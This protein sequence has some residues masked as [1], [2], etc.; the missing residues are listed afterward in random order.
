VG[1]CKDIWGNRAF[2]VARHLQRPLNTQAQHTASM[3]LVIAAAALSLASAQN[4]YT[5][6]GASFS[7]GYDGAVS[8]HAPPSPTL[9]VSHT[10]RPS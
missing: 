4:T 9:A 2:I 10:V 3:R 5:W 1:V 7:M 6:N 8:G